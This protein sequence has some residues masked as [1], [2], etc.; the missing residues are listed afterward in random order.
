MF[1]SLMNCLCHTNYNII[2][3][4]VIVISLKAGNC[5]RVLKWIKNCGTAY[6]KE[7]CDPHNKY[8]TYNNTIL[9]LMIKPRKKV[10]DLTS[11]TTLS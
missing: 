8:A 5:I 10:N 3:L 2:I 1:A 6:V 9:L 7:I 4:M 11:I